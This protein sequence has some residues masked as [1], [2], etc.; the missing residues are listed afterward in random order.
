MDN[1]EEVSFE[2]LVGETLGED[3][4]AT[5]PETTQPAEEIF[6][7]DQTQ[8]SEQ[9][10]QSISSA[11][12]SE[13][14]APTQQQE[15][16]TQQ[17]TQA[18]N[19]FNNPNYDENG[20]VVLFDGTII[21][22]G[23]PR[24]IFDQHVKPAMNKLIEA[25]NKAT[26]DNATAVGH[27]NNLGSILMRVKDEIVPQYER[28]IADLSGKVQAYEQAV[29]SVREYG[30][31]SEEAIEAHKLSAIYKSN[32]VKCIQLLIANAAEQGYDVSTLGVNFDQ[33]AIQK[34][35]DSRLNPILER[36]RNQQMAEQQRQE[37][38]IRANRFFSQ[39]PDAKVHEAEIA[40]MIQ[41]DNNLSPESAYY[42]LQ[43]AYRNNGLN[44][45][46]PLNLA[47]AEKQ[48]AN[49]REEPKKQVQLPTSG[50]GSANVTVPLNKTLSVSSSMSDIVKQAM[51]D[52]GINIK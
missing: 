33:V 16:Q 13:Q 49:Q 43:L 12:T 10:D 42:K 31:S 34:L 41:S 24:R 18:T 25:A 22:A 19:S 48:A 11:N 14:S 38:V 30:L 8:P 15:V 51:L 2:A 39:F 29:S 52:S 37:G 26:Q 40:H 50:R 47:M 7:D 28:Q 20:N 23:H 44:W 21:P 1:L 6:A 9:I 32:P 5:A 3:V 46:K 36:E 27:I 17:E 45:N 4:N 35:L